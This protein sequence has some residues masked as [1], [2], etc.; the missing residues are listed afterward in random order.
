MKR[1]FNRFRSTILS[2]LLLFAFCGAAAEP[3][4]SGDVVIRGWY[5]LV[6]ELVRHTP[7]YSP[8]VASRAFAYLGVTAYEAVAGGA[9]DLVSLAGQLNGLDTLPA[10]QADAVYD[11]AV[12]VNAALTAGA[13]AFFFN[14][15]PTGQRALGAM[16]ARMAERVASGVPADVVARSVTAGQAVA[17]HILAWSGTDG[18]AVV[19]NMGFPLEYRL[20]EGPAHWV[21]TS[22]IAQQQM[23]LLPQWGENRAFAMPTGKSCALPPPPAY[24]EAEGSAFRTEAEE[25]YRTVREITPEQRGVAR[26]WSDD[27]ML[28]PT[29]P[30]HWISI[31]LQL[32]ERDGE[33]AE[34]AADVLARLGVTLADAFIGCWASKYEFDL[35]RPVTYIRRVIDKGWEPLLITPPFPEYPSGHS[36]Q[37]G[38]AATVLAGFFGESF[39]FEDATHAADGLPP[40]RFGSFWQAAEEAG[41]SRLY[42]GIHFRAAIERGLDQGRCIGAHAVALRTRR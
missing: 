11:E 25:V 28:S 19:E 22:L 37:S 7:T 27:P 36:T 16:E 8:P 29:P 6:L 20:T 13:K 2:A 30:G 35:V 18:G 21:P 17:A 41:I 23:P 4:P 12:V 14:T 32:L 39:A 31:A 42:G 10:R 9:P 34:R 33:G 15:G 1:G 38:A 40:R 24:S 3:R 5:R 26:F